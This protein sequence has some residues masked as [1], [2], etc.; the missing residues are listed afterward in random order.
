MFVWLLLFFLLLLR[1]G[2]VVVLLVRS[3]PI[4]LAW[5]EKKAGGDLLRCTTF[6]LWELTRKTL[7]TRMMNKDVGRVKIRMRMGAANTSR[8]KATKATKA[9]SSKNNK[10]E[11]QHKVKNHTKAESKSKKKRKQQKQQNKNQTPKKIKLIHQKIRVQFQYTKS[12]NL[13]LSQICYQNKLSSKLV[14]EAV[15]HDLWHQLVGATTATSLNSLPIL[16]SFGAP[17]AL[18][19]PH[20][21][22]KI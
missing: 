14:T 10:S 5:L 19:I 15:N 22:E 11:K 21:I 20:D 16:R 6:H 1:L 2:V 3:G 12:S 7:L 13:H 8:T 18:Q 9:T 4:R 17:L